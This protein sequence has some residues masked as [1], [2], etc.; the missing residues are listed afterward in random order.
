MLQS[1]PDQALD[2]D[3]RGCVPAGHSAQGCEWALGTG[4]TGVRAHR[5]PGP[6]AMGSRY[7]HWALP[8][9]GP[10]ISPGASPRARQE[11]SASLASPSSVP[12]RAGKALQ[13]CSSP[14]SQPAS[15]PPSPQM[16]AGQR[17]ITPPLCRKGPGGGIPPFPGCRPRVP[18]PLP[19]SR[20]PRP[21]PPPSGQ[22]AAPS[23]RAV[24][25][26]TRS[27]APLAAN[28]SAAP[29]RR[30]RPRRA[31]PIRARRGCAGRRRRRH[32]G[33]RGGGSRQYYLLYC[34]YLMAAAE[35]ASPQRAELRGLGTGPSCCSPATSAMT[36]LPPAG[37]SH[38]SAYTHVR[39]NRKGIKEQQPT[40]RMFLL[41]NGQLCYNSFP[42]VRACGM[43]TSRPCPQSY[44][45]C[46]ERG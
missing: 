1:I 38:P 25:W 22:R 7:S 42:T 45:G 43:G 30:A 2:S 29:A 13:P 44:R 5:S 32:G 18:L 27:S 33:P 36:W 20:A 11:P 9:A 17:A 40:F 8:T 35:R 19:R 12:A 34:E 28:H 10:Q 23:P 3:P 24:S 37:M 31:R 6:L 15:L 41:L 16:D 4:H 14:G 21:H 39:L 26:G 46:R